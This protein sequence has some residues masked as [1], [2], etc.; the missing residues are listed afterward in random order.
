[1][2]RLCIYTG[3]ILGGYAG[4]AL[5]DTLGLGFAWSFVLSSAGSLAGVFAGWK[6]A[7][8]LEE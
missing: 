1:M 2:N 6:V 3:T 8:K 4:W 5:G 7:R